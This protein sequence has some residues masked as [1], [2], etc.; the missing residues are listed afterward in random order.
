MKKG[1]VLLLTGLLALGMMALPMTVQA[2]EV[3]FSITFKGGSEDVGKLLFLGA[4]STFFNVDQKFVITYHKED[5]DFLETL[6][7]FYLAGEVGVDPDEIIILRRRGLGWGEVAK[8]YGL[9]PNFH[10]KHLAKGK[11][12]KHVVI[13]APLSDREF[14]LVV[15]R[16]FLWEYYAVPEEVVIIWLNRGLD[17]YDIFIAVN[18]AARVRVEPARII[19]LRVKGVSWEA[20][21]VQ[22]RVKYEELTRP[23]L[24]KQRYA[25]PIVIKKRHDD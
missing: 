2:D 20:I 12:K 3:S 14:E 16:R 8:H 5:G 25:R 9:P 15:F 22:Y 11:G 21:A 19:E 1:R 18:L 4:L 6:S 24:P 17:P 23:V 7:A 13:V 10:G